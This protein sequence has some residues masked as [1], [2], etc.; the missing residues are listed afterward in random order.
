MNGLGSTFS[1]GRRQPLITVKFL[2]PGAQV[3][4][5]NVTPVLLFPSEPNRVFVFNQVVYNVINGAGYN[6]TSTNETIGIYRNAFGSIPYA[7]YSD[8]ALGGIGLLLTNVYYT[9]VCN[10]DYQNNDFSNPYISQDLFLDTS[11]QPDPGG[12][13]DLQMF[14]IGNYYYF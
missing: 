9:M 4:N 5:L 1:F 6:F 10:F 13:G 11:I 7:V 14:C 8:P 3:Q 12:S 2:I